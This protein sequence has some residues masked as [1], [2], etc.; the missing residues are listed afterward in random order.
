MQQHGL[1]SVPAGYEVHHIIPLCQGGA[2][3]PDNM[4]LLSAEE[5]ARV[6]AA[7]SAYYGWGKQ[8]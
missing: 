8:V 4:I 7:H 5:H 2:D 6:T 1:D 3:T